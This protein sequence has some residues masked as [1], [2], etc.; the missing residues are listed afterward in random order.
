M[1]VSDESGLQESSAYTGTRKGMK[2][3]YMEVLAK[4]HGL[5]VM[6]SASRGA[7]RSVVGEPGKRR[8]AIE[9]RNHPFGAPTLSEAGEGNTAWTAMAR[10][11]SAP[12]SRRTWHAWTPCGQE[13][14]EPGRVRLM[15]R[16]GR[17]SPSGRTRDMNAARKSDMVI[18]PW[19]L[20]NKVI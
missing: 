1:E 2:E 4:H 11:M 10:D 19:S 6:R 16:T 18:V 8:R 13:P 7:G 14:R 20:S 5:A 17:E 15:W 9:L 3:P 12:R